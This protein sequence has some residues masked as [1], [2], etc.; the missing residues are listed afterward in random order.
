VVAGPHG[1]AFSNSIYMAPGASLIEFHRQ[2]PWQSRPR[3]KHLKP[4]HG[5]NSP[6]YALLSRALEL[7]YWVVVDTVSEASQRGYNISHQALIDTVGTALAL[8]VGKVQRNGDP[9]NEPSTLLTDSDVVVV[10]SWIRTKFA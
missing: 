9:K 1:A 5:S 8:S 2:Q 4:A 7:H 6:L 3:H 10:P